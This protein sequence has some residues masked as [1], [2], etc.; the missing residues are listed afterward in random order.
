LLDTLGAVKSQ[1]EENQRS[2][3]EDDEGDIFGAPCFFTL[4]KILQQKISCP[5]LAKSE[6]S[7]RSRAV[8]SV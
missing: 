4:A 2:K 5:T 8:P 3:E 6:P 7:H 1:I